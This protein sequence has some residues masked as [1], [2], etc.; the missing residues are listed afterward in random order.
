MELIGDSDFNNDFAEA[1]KNDMPKYHE[2]MGAIISY[3]KFKDKL[4]NMSINAEFVVRMITGVFY[5]KQ[6]KS[7]QIHNCFISLL[8]GNIIDADRLDY[9]CRDVWAS[10]YSTSN[11]DL[12]RLISALHI[13]R[14]SEKEYV[15]CFESNSLNEI[16]GVLNVKDFQ[17][18]YVFNHH[19]V[20]YDQWLLTQAACTM[21]LEYYPNIKQD[22]DGTLALGEIINEESIVDKIILPKNN[23]CVSNLSDDDL[24]FL[25]KQS[26]NP[27]YIE[28]SSRQYSHYPLWKSRD[29]FL[30]YFD[31]ENPNT[32]IE[33]SRFEQMI[34]DSLAKEDVNDIIITKAIFKPRVKMNSLYVVVAGQVIRYTDIYPKTEC[35]NKNT[36]FYYVFLPKK[37]MDRDEIAKKKVVIID[38]LKSNIEKMY[39]GICQ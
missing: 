36:L 28:W 35:N 24:V 7:H 19:T 14:N 22:N 17:G 39:R 9:A 11:I 10:G 2:L 38:E 20:S 37:N 6:S 13:K 27:Y 32:Q 26:H 31:I 25:M 29:E 18:K 21:A 30:Y 12:R 33:K 1:E 15:V 16:E 3:S 23:L 34:K 4:N 5:V 8:H